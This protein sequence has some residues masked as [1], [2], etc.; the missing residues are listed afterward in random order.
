M[1]F[2]N[3]EDDL[4]QR[5]LRFNLGPW[6]LMR[7]SGAPSTRLTT[8]KVLEVNFGLHNKAGY[9]WEDY[10]PW[11]RF[12][13]HFPSVKTLQVHHPMARTLHQDYGEPDN[14]AFLPALEEIELYTCSMTDNIQPES[15]LAAFQPFVSA[16]QQAGRSV[17][18]FFRR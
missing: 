13:Q 15:Q 9:V 10:I 18:V 16:R 4:G 7:L 2:Q 17:K 11:S 14:P 3:L 12:Y 6:S 1:S 8:V 5:E